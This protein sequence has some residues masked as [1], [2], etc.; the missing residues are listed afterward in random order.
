MGHEIRSSGMPLF[1]EG[2]EFD[3]L[4]QE[5]LDRMNQIEP[6]RWKIFNLKEGDRYLKL[7]KFSDR[8]QIWA[9][10]FHGIDDGKHQHEGP[11]KEIDLGD[12]YN[13]SNV[14]D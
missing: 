3:G 14:I 6:I 9:P 8:R 12:S 2:E 5:L 4:I 13:G 11:A 7:F 1:P 10:V